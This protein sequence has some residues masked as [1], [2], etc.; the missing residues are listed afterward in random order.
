MIPA[1]ASSSFRTKLMGWIPS[2]SS[3]H[4]TNV[5]NCGKGAF[6][7]LKNQFQSPAKPASTHTATNLTQA[8]VTQPPAPAPQISSKRRVVI[9]VAAAT[10]AVVTVG[11]GLFRYYFQS[12]E[13]QSHGN[14]LPQSQDLD[15]RVATTFTST[16]A[17][18]LTQ[19]AT[20]LAEPITQVASALAEP[21][22]D[23]GKK[24]LS[25]IPLSLAAQAVSNAVYSFVAQEEV[26]FSQ[27]INMGDLFPISGGRVVASTTSPLPP[28]IE[29]LQSQIKEIN[30]FSTPNT[31]PMAASSKVIYI[32][33]SQTGSVPSSVNVYNAD[34]SNPFLGNVFDAGTVVSNMI[35][36]QDQQ[37]IALTGPNTVVK[38]YDISKPFNPNY[39]CGLL[40]S[41]VTGNAVA[42]AGNGQYGCAT[43]NGFFYADGNACEITGFIPNM[44]GALMA[45]SPDC[46]YVATPTGLVCTSTTPS[47]SPLSTLPI[48]G[49]Y[50]L[51]YL[52]GYCYVGTT[53]NF[54][55][56]ACPPSGSMQ[57][58]STL[59]A[60]NIIYSM[61]PLGNLLYYSS[62]SNGFGIMDVTNITN[63]VFPPSFS[64]LLPQMG[65]IGIFVGL[66]DSLG[67]KT[68]N[69]FH[70]VFPQDSITFS[71]TPPGGAQETY[72]VDVEATTFSGSTTGNKKTVT[73]T[74]KQ[75]ITTETP[76]QKFIAIVDQAFNAAL[77]ATAFKHVHG[78]QMKYNFS[79]Q[80]G[81]RVT[82]RI[83]MNALTS[84]FSGTPRAGDQGL[85]NCTVQATD[86][87]SAKATL[88]FEFE[89]VDAPVIRTISNPL[90][91][92]GLP[93][94]LNLNEFVQQSNGLTFS[95][96][97][98]PPSFTNVNGII[99]GNATS[100]DLGTHPITITVTDANGVSSTQSITLNAVQPG[101]PQFVQNPPIPPVTVV[102]N[103][104]F[105]FD[106]PEGTAVNPTN[107]D[108][109]INYEVTLA[110][111]SPLPGWM[112]C[113]QITVGTRVVTR[114][115]GN[116]PYTAKAFSDIIL[117]LLLRAIQSSPLVQLA[118]AAFS[119]VIT[120]TGYGQILLSSGS[121][122]GTA[123]I[124]Y[125]NR[126]VIYNNYVIKSPR[127]MA[128]LNTFRCCCCRRE[129]YQYY[130]SQEEFF[131]GQS[132][133][134]TYITD[135][136]KIHD[137]KYFYDDKPV[138]PGGEKPDWFKIVRVDNTRSKLYAECVPLL[139]GVQAIKVIAKNKG[140]LYLETVTFN[141]SRTVRFI[142]PCKT[143][144]E[145]I[146]T[147]KFYSAD[148]SGE[149]L[150][151]RRLS[152]ASPPNGLKYDRESNSIVA[153]SAPAT[154]II[155]RLF[156]SDKEVLET[157]HFNVQYSDTFV[158]VT[159]EDGVSSS[160][161]TDSSPAVASEAKSK[162]SEKMDSPV[163]VSSATSGVVISEAKSKSSE[164]SDAP[165]VII[166][167]PTVASPSSA[168]KPL[169]TST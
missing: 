63:P 138:S 147:V 129:P 150:R 135:S 127:A 168:S 121:A 128:I 70:F 144:R 14:S 8:V 22:I 1:P 137:Y 6:Q 142:R 28:G 32:A 86:S 108:I 35:V 83:S 102:T 5:W 69:G 123:L 44:N 153:E 45:A 141:R 46:Y 120:G 167:L 2:P 97:N 21:I 58:V 122:L 7:S 13:P 59:P 139:T 112:S 72:N 106:I 80:I 48:T 81:N 143:A 34:P 49:I 39:K 159:E 36:D 132:L 155:A 26:A 40:N 161:K 75:A 47:S 117:G 9:V 95:V 27:S 11:Y 107:P 162:S 158:E 94:Y 82:P 99:S 136:R 78:S 37:Q 140:R 156:G 73:I 76:I 18:P 50:S 15:L 79:C 4:P 163:V 33:S 118:S 152:L 12:Q 53:S 90:V 43:N 100:Q 92:I 110:D 60:H 133:D 88:P 68:S 93:F 77:P 56:V 71:G 52:N 134:Y 103:S 16:L 89:V 105:E 124:V 57:I 64:G 126:K 146:T 67:I 65:P 87:L 31:G 17:K 62:F 98:L 104:Y 115:S 85:A 111:G 23:A 145:K 130:E 20:A 3:L 131:E 164:K 119:L 51:N 38:L 157:I 96:S 166:E 10:V 42:T 24:L 41:T 74:V 61:F 116:P 165:V 54:F 148:S 30:S 169:L 101:V 84:Q 91:T 160:S 109:P 19:V 29:L 114:C 66:G 154:P 151:R 125:R 149:S 113:Y 25:A 55:V